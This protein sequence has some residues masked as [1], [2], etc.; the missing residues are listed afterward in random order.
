MGYVPGKGI[1]KFGTGIAE[2]ISE[3]ANKGRL[4]LGYL[5]KGL[6]SEDVQW[7]LEAVS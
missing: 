5:L 1:G 4:G 3:A 2:P 6:E 7:E